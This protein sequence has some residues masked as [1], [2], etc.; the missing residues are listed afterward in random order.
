MA[1][2]TLRSVCWA[3]I[4]MSGTAERTQTANS[5]RRDAT[6]DRSGTTTTVPLTCTCGAI[7]SQC[8][9]RCS[10]APSSSPLRGRRTPARYPRRPWRDGDALAATSPELRWT[11][12]A[13]SRFD[14]DGRRPPSID[15]HHDEVWWVAALSHA[16]VGG[17]GLSVAALLSGPAVL[18]AIS[19]LAFLAGLVALGVL[20]FREARSGGG[21]VLRAVGRGLRTIWSWLWSLGP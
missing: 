1:A 4:R 14:R 10:T 12:M 2:S 13:R 21:S 8:C 17:I 6:S 9:S 7:G 20:S 11:S 3:S 5:R 18:V 19:S 15:E 16:L